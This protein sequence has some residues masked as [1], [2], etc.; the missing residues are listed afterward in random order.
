MKSKLTQYVAGAF[1]VVVLIMFIAIGI[2]TIKNPPERRRTP[3]P[4]VPPPVAAT[5]Q[6][7]PPAPIV[8]TPAPLTQP[9]AKQESAR[10]SAAND[11][12]AIAY[13]V[14]EFML[15]NGFDGAIVGATGDNS[16]ILFIQHPELTRPIIAELAAQG[17]FTLAK[18]YKFSQIECTNGKLLANKHWTFKVPKSSP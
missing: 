13:G 2:S 18:K 11:R 9:P 17:L 5:P 14:R 16:D 8:Q 6:A 7:P 1:A 4:G 3:S 15:E 10:D 12:K